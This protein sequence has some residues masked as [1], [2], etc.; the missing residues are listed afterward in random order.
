MRIKSK[1]VFGSAINLCLIILAAGVAWQGVS[2]ALSRL[3]VVEIQDDL[4]ASFLEM[5]LSEKNYFL[6]GDDSALSEIAS[7]IAS[8]F[9]ELR[10]SREAIE[11]GA[12]TEN[13]QALERYLTGYA[14][15]VEKTRAT[16]A[17]GPKAE[18][19]LRE[20]GRQLREFS[21]NM[22]RQVRAQVNSIL[23]STRHIMTVALVLI[24]FTGVL[25]VPLLF[26]KILASLRKLESLAKTIA[27]GDFSQIEEPA[28]DDEVDSTVRAM[29]AMSRQLSSRE[30]ELLQ[31]KKLASL[32]VLT[33]GVAHEITNPL[34]N[35]SMLAQTF[36]G[37]YQSFDDEARL[38]MMRQ[39]EHEVTRIQEI[40]SHLL[41]F[42]KP[43]K[44]EPER[45]QLND[46][47]KG[48]LR[49]VNNMLHVSNMH[50]ELELAE[51]LDP[52]RVNAPQI[53]QVLVNLVTN[54]I[55]AMSE[56][57]TVRL[58]TSASPEPGFARITVT[59]TG[60]GIPPEHLPH[61][62]DPFF[63]TKGVEGSGLGLSVSYGIVKNHGGRLH[64]ESVVGQGT[65]FTVDLPLDISKDI[66][67][68]MPQD[69]PQ[70][71]RPDTVRETQAETRRDD[72]AR[73]RA[74]VRRADDEEEPERTAQ[75]AARA[76][77]KAEE[78]DG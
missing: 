22:V 42:S 27:G 35:I 10:S 77:E 30:A 34:N 61:I 50:A 21:S 25:S 49:L 33:A 23:A 74:A 5:R 32:G 19:A 69:A 39:V 51:S 55:Q 20:S 48:A 44:V 36:E 18:A 11:R 56:G 60:K 28:G 66:P 16:G 45:A 71:A 41:D 64:A 24:V 4:N 9:E 68:D 47:V 58:A 38:G 54:A 1:L 73:A 53:Q 2:G 76:D 13:Y 37:F 75:S 57:G 65:V 15:A 29:N 46:V 12:G 43:K 63:S 14:A 40:V 70:D 67:Q 8:C 72:E 59:D 31:S 17:R 6:F 26:R 78:N 7:R 62:F 3:R 52:V